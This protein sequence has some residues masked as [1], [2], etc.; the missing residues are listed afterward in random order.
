MASFLAAAAGSI[1][2]MN[3]AD[4]SYD[5]YERRGFRDDATYDDYEKEHLQ[6]V[7]LGV[8]AAALWGVAVVDAYRNAYNPLWTRRP[9]SVDV[10]ASSR[11]IRVRWKKRW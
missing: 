4:D 3:E 7:L 6:S 1:H 11:E 9:G 10:L 8:A 5:E 2:L